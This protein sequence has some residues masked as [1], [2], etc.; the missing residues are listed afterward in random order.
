MTQDTE[1]VFRCWQGGQHHPMTCAACGCC[2][3]CAQPDPW[4]L[5]H[6]V[7]LMHEQPRDGAHYTGVM[8]RVI[9]AVDGW[10]KEQG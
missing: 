3:D 4:R 10:R 2:A 7:A 5:L 9:N 1:Q 6:E 8:Q